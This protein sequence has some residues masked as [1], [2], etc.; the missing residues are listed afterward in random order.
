MLPICANG[1]PKITSWLIR[2][3]IKTWQQHICYFLS[4]GF[5]FSPGFSLNWGSFFLHTWVLAYNSW[6]F[7]PILPGA[8]QVLPTRAPKLVTCCLV[9]VFYHTLLNHE[10]LQLTFDLIH[11]M[12]INSNANLVTKYKTL[13]VMKLSLAIKYHKSNAEISKCYGHN[14][15]NGHHLF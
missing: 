3:K 10:T 12:S 7:C 2:E 4:Q 9:S 8:G 1:G 5:L 14:F 13:S 6:S 15:S 11:C